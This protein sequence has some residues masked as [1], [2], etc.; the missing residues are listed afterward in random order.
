MKNNRFRLTSFTTMIRT[1]FLLGLS[2]GLLLMP[3]DRLHAFQVGKLSFYVTND[4]LY[5]YNY[6]ARQHQFYESLS[7]FGTYRQWS[8][9]LTLRANNFYLQTPNQ[10]LDN[11]QVE[12]YRK[13]IQYNGKYFKVHIGDFYSL[14]GR[15]MV[16]SVLKNE[17][18]LLE[19]TILG[20]SI[21]YHRGRLDIKALAGQV[22]DETNV[23]EWF[24]AGGEIILEYLENH[25]IGAHMSY[26][27]DIDAPGNQGQRVATSF[28]IQGSRLFNSFSYYA[29]AGWLNTNDP[30]QDNGFG[31][32]SNIT[33]SHSHVTAYLEYK[34][35]K[36]FNNEMNNPPTG[37][38]EDE[39]SNLNDAEG[40]RLYFQYAFLEPDITLFANVGHYREYDDSGLHIYGGFT[41]EDLFDRLSLSAVYGVKDLYY[42]VKRF[43]SH[44]L[45]QWNDRWST[46]ITVKHKY[47]KDKSFTF[48]EQDYTFQ[49]SV[50]PVWSIFF[51]HQYS[52]NKVMGMNHFYSGGVKFY[53]TAA[54]VL[55]VSGG[56][57]RGGQICSGGQCFV[58]PPFKG[59]KF[60]LFHTFK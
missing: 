18:V 24:A 28:S 38:R 41:I 7:I 10:T 39:I 42:P 60:A 34:H 23:R 3:M 36:D 54:T 56:T 50:S 51:L 2:F 48:D 53:L 31:L 37:D 43:D 16:L 47:Y 12:M 49:V 11:P 9:G 14:L 46:E 55:E 45:Y 40:L 58:A 15:G 25:R 26:I 57:I 20:G 35:Y 33:F 8:V 27:N 52:H 6:G 44:L 30:F 32:Y 4:S 29:E 17:D 19:R 13:Y 5:Q 22:K 59:I 21:E 1:L